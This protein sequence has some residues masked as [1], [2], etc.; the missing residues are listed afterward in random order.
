M[1]SSSILMVEAIE[2]HRLS[3]VDA[4]SRDGY[5]V[6][7]AAT[8]EKAIQVVKK[9]PFDL[10]IVSMEQ[11]VSLEKLLT[12][13][14]PDTGILM[15]ATAD[16]ISCL[17]DDAGAGIRSF[18]VP[19]VSQSRLRE[20]V[21]HII[22]GIKQAKHSIRQEL[23]SSLEDITRLP[24]SEAGR[25]HF[26][27]QIVETGAANTDADYVSLIV[28]DEDTGMLVSRS[29]AGDVQPNW[30]K[31]CREIA[32]SR[33]PVLLHQAMRNH[34]A[35]R[36]QMLQAG[37][38]VILYVPLVVKGEVVGA[39][40]HVKA[41]GEAQ[42][43]AG[44]IDFATV[45]GR[46][47]S[48]SLEN[49]RLYD[50][51]RQQYAHSQRLLQEI[52]VAQENERR[53]M[54]IEIHDSVAQ[55]MVGASY[56]I[57]ACSSLVSEMRFEELKQELDTA[58]QATQRSIRELRRTIA[59]LR[60]LPL[61][62]MGLIAAIRQS[63]D[64][65]TEDGITCHIEVNEDLPDISVAEETTIYRIVQEI[66]T[67]IRRHAGASEVT[68]RMRYYNG[69]YIVEVSDNGQGFSPEKV[70]NNRMSPAHMG[71]IGMKERAELLNGY[72][73]IESGPGKGTTIRFSF[74]VSNREIIKE[75]A[76]VQD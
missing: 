54:A 8:I 22:N 21:A 63:M 58:R 12:L 10:V 18:L 9:E 39:L 7:G 37:I 42:F 30:E 5:S 6:T 60:P 19:P 47:S 64:S 46:L 32:G 2:H 44:D 62:E 49:I 51:T 29:T 41:A 53:R 59:N 67:N 13:I 75:T 72:L 24:V 16:T 56:G 28:R 20:R 45:L 52:T 33:E 74:P 15:I 48:M 25:S 31:I 17:T 65:L 26:F 73:T 35:L 76:T 23:L 38:S 66:V 36:R 71:I 57:K 61:E 69:S 43:T 3:R 68:V 70:A 34:S 1:R 50:I 14:P 55:W 40:N 27:R 11:P 4:L